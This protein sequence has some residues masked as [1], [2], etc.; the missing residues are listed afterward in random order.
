MMTVITACSCTSAVDIS[1]VSEPKAIYAL[2]CYHVQDMRCTGHIYPPM[3]DHIPGNPEEKWV[4]LATAN[5]GNIS[6][7]A[8]VPSSALVG[9]DQALMVLL[10]LMPSAADG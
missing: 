7:I 3:H 6:G 8:A 4:A 5:P 1:R 9:N 2:T 10:A